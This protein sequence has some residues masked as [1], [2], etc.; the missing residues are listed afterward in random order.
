MHL[1]PE[2]GEP[3]PANRYLYSTLQSLAAASQEGEGDEWETDEAQ[4]PSLDAYL[5]Q[6]T[7]EYSAPSRAAWRSESEIPQLL[8]FDQFEEILTLDP[9][10]LEVKRAF[11]EELGAA[12]VKPNRWALFVLREDYLAALDPYRFIIPT[13]FTNRYRLESLDPQAAVEAVVATA[14]S[15]GVHFDEAAAL[16]LVDNL[17]RRGRGTDDSDG[18]QL[19]PYVEPMQLQVVGR[20]TEFWPVTSK[21]SKHVVLQ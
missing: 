4:R 16:L 18:D 20:V 6:L 11:F 14:A 13:R 2:K 12:L 8:I 5:D 1:M 19:A 10:D 15:A 3:E 21:I 9:D 7:A 17:R